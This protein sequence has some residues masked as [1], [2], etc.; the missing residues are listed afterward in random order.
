MLSPENNKCVKSTIIIKMTIFFNQG[1]ALTT[2]LT[3]GS[4]TTLSIQLMQKKN[5]QVTLQASKNVFA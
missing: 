5:F 4:P 3:I 2:E 1:C